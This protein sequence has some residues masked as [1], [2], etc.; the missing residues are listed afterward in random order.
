MTTQGGENMKC[1]RCKS[2]GLHR[3]NVLAY[4]EIVYGYS[5]VICGNWIEDDKVIKMREFPPAEQVSRKWG[6]CKCGA[7]VDLSKNSDGV[8]R[9]CRTAAKL[10]AEVKRSERRAA[11]L[12]SAG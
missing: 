6:K 11:C 1:P 7:K 10:K 12:S 5:C 3:I 4:N 2:S 9:S 8:C